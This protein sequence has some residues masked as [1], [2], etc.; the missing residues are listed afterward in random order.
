MLANTIGFI[1]GLAL[2]A[3]GCFGVWWAFRAPNPTA[4]I[5]AVMGGWVCFIPIIFGALLMA[6]CLG[7]F[8]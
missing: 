7:A 8:K 3:L 5:I 1:G 4:H 2:V 6:Y